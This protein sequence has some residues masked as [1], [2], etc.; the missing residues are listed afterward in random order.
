MSNRCSLGTQGSRP[1]FR[2]QLSFL[3]PT[4]GVPL[5]SCPG[6]GFPAGLAQNKLG[7]HD[8][9]GIKLAVDTYSHEQEKAR[10]I[11]VFSRET[12]EGQRFDQWE[13]IPRSQTQLYVTCWRE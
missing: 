11:D 3:C 2:T 5:W 1:P 8:H 9:L 7:C 4:A 10:L 12:A 6:E 13:H